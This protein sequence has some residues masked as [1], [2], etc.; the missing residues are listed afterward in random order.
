MA[1][2]GRSSSR[3]G[4]FRGGKDTSHAPIPK[5][6]SKATFYLEA[7]GSG[8]SLDSAAKGP[9][10]L[11]ITPPGAVAVPANFPSTVNLTD[12]WASFVTTFTRAGYYRIKAE[13]PNGSVGRQTVDVGVH[14]NTLPTP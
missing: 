1:G 14:A 13:G 6:N 8:L 4:A 2:G 11:T 10:T 7:N 12:G 9:V 5:L 3:S